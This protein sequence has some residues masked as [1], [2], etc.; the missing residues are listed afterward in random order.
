MLK[1]CRAIVQYDQRSV[2]APVCAFRVLGLVANASGAS[3]SLIGIR[4][5]CCR[6][7]TKKRCA[8]FLLNSSF[9]IFFGGSVWDKFQPEFCLLPFICNSL[10]VSLS[11]IS[12][13]IS[14][15]PSRGCAGGFPEGRSILTPTRKMRFKFKVQSAD[16]SRVV[17]TLCEQVAPSRRV[18][19]T[20]SPSSQLSN[21]ASIRTSLRLSLIRTHRPTLHYS[22]N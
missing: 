20:F 19:R 16:R 8:E 17:V 13:R 4:Q 6:V 14:A 7:P 10:E 22:P 12:A 2:P 15:S 21:C 1:T 5:S 18:L 3:I 11:R 9:F